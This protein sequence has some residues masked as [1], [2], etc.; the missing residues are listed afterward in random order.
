MNKLIFGI[1]VV[2]IFLACGQV[3]VP[4]EQPAFVMNET[5]GLEKDSSAL[6][7]DI[8]KNEDRKNIDTIPKQQKSETD[9]RKIFIKKHKIADFEVDIY[10][11]GSFGWSSEKLQR[12][13]YKEGY[14]SPLFIKELYPGIMYYNKWVQLDSESNNVSTEFD[15][16]EYYDEQG[17]LLNTFKSGDYNPYL[18]KDL[19]SINYTSTLD[20]LV[21]ENTGFTSVIYTLDR[22]DKDSYVIGFQ[23]ILI[24]IDTLGKEIN[25]LEDKEL[26][27][28]DSYVTPDSKFLA[29]CSGG[30]DDYGSFKHD[31]LDR[32]RDYEIKIYDFQNMS[33]IY[34]KTCK[35]TDGVTYWDGTENWIY[36]RAKND[37]DENI[38]DGHWYIIDPSN[39]REYH[40]LFTKD[41]RKKIL[42]LKKKIWKYKNYGHNVFSTFKFQKREF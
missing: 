17:I 34:E 4:S 6:A 35:Y 21:D 15:K 25:R 19:S 3:K 24:V 12:E 18:E 8:E 28:S 9:S 32:Y 36:F 33:L 16:L 38:Y 7:L 26:F 13:I 22:S 41:D 37:E 10:L 11:T 2:L 20:I 14:R 40:R 39:R 5:N 42:K 27:V 30:L 31:S 1:G 29:I 23:T